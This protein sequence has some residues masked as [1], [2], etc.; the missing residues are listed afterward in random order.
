MTALFL[1][2]IV[3]IVQ[4]FNPS[5]GY[6]GLN[7]NTWIRFS[8]IPMVGTQPAKTSTSD[9]RQDVIDL[10][11]SNQ[12]INIG[13]PHTDS[14]R[15]KISAANK[16]KVPWNVGKSHSEETRNKIAEKTRE[17]MQQKKIAKL[18]ALGM[19]MEDY[20]LQRVQKRKEKKRSAVKGGLT[21]EGRKRISES[22]KERWKNPEFR[23]KY[24]SS[25]RGA[26]NH[27]EATR[28][29]ISEAITLKW[30][31]QEYRDKVKSKP[32]DEVRARISETLKSKW[33][34]EE[35]RNKMMSLQFPRTEAWR[36]KLSESI[37]TKWLDPEYRASVESG[38]RSSNKTTTR[39]YNPSNRPRRSQSRSV[40][41]PRKPRIS[42]ED[43]R[44]KKRAERLEKKEKEHS[45][46]M[47]F[48]MAKEEQKK[49]GGT[50]R[51]KELLGRELWFEEKVC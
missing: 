34:E 36:I 21:D 43:M 25:Q 49:T 33:K 1:I 35:F 44:A 2:F 45:R 50:S 47:A 15:A 39:A 31:Q 11:V 29:R 9:L 40:S 51:L 30:Q 46:K 20:D 18:A 4:L 6:I 10:S 48:K 17:A 13:R 3:L 8:D 42:V 22:V 14:S 37:K 27:S 41:T 16:G 19:T 24:S 5:R 38:I 32:S 7:R 26:R 23:A 12:N 28:A